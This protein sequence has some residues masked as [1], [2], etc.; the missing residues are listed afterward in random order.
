MSKVEF[1][2]FQMNDSRTSLSLWL[3]F[4]RMLKDDNDISIAALRHITKEIMIMGAT[5]GADE[6]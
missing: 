5:K 6:T 2:I 1:S 4:T 3:P